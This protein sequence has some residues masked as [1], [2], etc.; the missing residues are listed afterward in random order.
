MLF[1]VTCLCKPCDRYLKI[2]F[3]DLTQMPEM[4]ALFEYDCP[5][6]MQIH[7]D[8]IGAVGNDDGMLPSGAIVGRIVG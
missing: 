8:R 3:V 6:D 7:S 2:Y 5:N 1:S 4:D